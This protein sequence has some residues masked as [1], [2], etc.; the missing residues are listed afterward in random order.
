MDSK[1]SEDDQDLFDVIKKP[2]TK[3][4]N[5]V[6]RRAVPNINL[7]DKIGSISMNGLNVLSAL[8]FGGA[9]ATHLKLNEIKK[10]K[11]VHNLPKMLSLDSRMMD[12]ILK[13]EDS[14]SSS[15]A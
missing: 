3:F 4:T 1:Q 7:Q 10:I 8:R 6:L 11:T 15:S 14:D 13:K 12:G 2:R 5:S 9:S